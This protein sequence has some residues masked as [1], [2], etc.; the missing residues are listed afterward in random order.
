MLNF[1]QFELSAIATRNDPPLSHER[2]PTLL[3]VCHRNDDGA[4]FVGYLFACPMTAARSRLLLARRDFVATMARSIDVGSYGALFSGEA[5][6]AACDDLYWQSPLGSEYESF[7]ASC[8]G[9]S[10]GS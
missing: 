8:A 5:G 6:D 3:P 4:R 9:R 7:G 10:C 2:D 1:A